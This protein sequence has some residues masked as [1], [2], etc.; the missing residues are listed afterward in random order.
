[1]NTTK[2]RRGC[3]RVL[4][5]LVMLFT[6]SGTTSVLAANMVRKAKRNTVTSARLIAR[7]K[8][9]R[10]KYTGG[11]RCG[12]YAKDTWLR[13][14]GRIY[15]FDKKGYARK[16]F[17]TYGGKRYYTG[18]DGTIWHRRWLKR[19]SRWYYLKKNG[20]KASLETLEID[21]ASYTFKKGGALDE[22][23]SDRVRTASD[24]VLIAGDSRT[25]G[26]S[27]SVSRANTSYIG[28][29]SEGYLWLA[30][31][32]DKEVCSYLQKNP[33]ANVIFCFGVNDLGYVYRYIGY[34]REIMREYPDASFWFMS[35]NPIGGVSNPYLSNGKIEEFNR[36]LK[37]AFRTQYIDTYTYLVQD[38]FRTSDGIHYLPETYRKIYDYTMK[39]IR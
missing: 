10:L 30:S 29:V 34:Y 22:Q 24:K 4:L 35:V 2:F 32:A 27:L 28:K 36:I 3:L 14:E 33:T 15:Y 8:G 1:M 18:K 5:L 11:A 6:I 31:S 38:G 7:A 23:K 25:V 12:K 16:G 17:F 9:L 21:G 26:M 20:E 19:G 37:S 39:Q 13:F